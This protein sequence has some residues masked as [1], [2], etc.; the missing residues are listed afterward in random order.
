MVSNKKWWG[1]P[2]RILQT[3][4][5]LDQASMDPEKLVH[6][7]IQTDTNALVFNVGGIYAWYP[8][9][10]SCHTR[11]PLLQNDYDL[12]G[13]VIKQCHKNGIR[14][15]ARFDFSKAEDK[16]YY[17]KPEWFIR[18]ENN[19][20]LVVAADRPGAWP[21][22]MS[23]CP[24][25]G[26]Q[27]EAVAF[28]VLR[29]AM[30]KYELD[31]I[32][33][34]SMFY[35]PCL[36]DTCKKK[37]KD[38]YGEDLPAEPWKCDPRWYDACVDERIS[39]Y[40][41]IIKKENPDTAFFH[42]FLLWDNMD[43]LKTYQATKWW[44]YD[45]GEYD[46]F[47]T[48]PQDIVHSETHDM[49][50]QGVGMLPRDWLPG[51]S[52]NLGQSLTPDAPP[53]DIVHTGPGLTWR[54]TG[55][56]P[57]EHRFW[58]NQVVANG[59]YVCH[60]LTG[61]PETVQDK[62]ILKTISEFHRDVK[63]V[64][65]VMEGAVSAAQV[66]LV[67]NPEA[68]HGWVEALTGNQIPYALILARHA[69]KLTDYSVVIFPEKTRWSDELVSACQACVSAGGSILIEGRIPDEFGS[70]G[71]LAGV[72]TLGQ[73]EVMKSSYLRFEGEKNP[74]QIGMEEVKILP[75]AGTLTYEAVEDD[76]TEIL[77]TFIPPFSPPEGAGSPPERAMFLVGNTDIPTV[78]LRR[79]QNGRVAHITFAMHTML[80][81]Y[82]LEEHY[83]LISNLIDL[84]LGERKLVSMDRL[85][86]VQLSC[87]KKDRTLILHLVNGAGQRPL[88]RTIT[89]R[90]IDLVIRVPENASLK[91]AK[92]LVTGQT[93]S[94]R[95]EQ[96]RI[97]LHLSELNA[98]EAIFLEW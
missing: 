94:H 25:G 43:S 48:H 83:Q 63:K 79:L 37:Y 31:G 90:D 18:Q 22:L 55:L 47:N 53:M 98:W 96:D 57:A 23:T 82:R 66:A 41:Q 34:T 16:T 50:N 74:L 44:F 54:H 64:E 2:H 5:Q 6:Q 15:I 67:W 61:I 4:L 68:G 81:S 71:E 21:L 49:L 46:I 10:V 35:A 45:P 13:E 29:E 42:R 85:P 38:L 97:Y 30:S 76:K 20:P 12:V 17:Q 62:R 14:F 86:G 77:S 87:F 78:T 70:L 95:Q 32:F 40:Y 93:V 24:N 1:K 8:T 51:A 59:G 60:S 28:P 52:M 73:S 39:S 75:F 9:E 7:L 26:Y 91:M 88:R 89:L 84:L 36:C 69:D 80:D 33:I 92:A 58:L 11:N 19:K 72:R 27:N 3:N 56:S 65:P